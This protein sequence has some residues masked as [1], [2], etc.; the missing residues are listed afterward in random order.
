VSQAATAHRNWQTDCWREHRPFHCVAAHNPSLMAAAAPDDVAASTESLQA[1]SL[2]STHTA[3]PKHAPF[4]QPLAP[5][6]NPKPLAAAPSAVGAAASAATAAPKPPS[7]SSST[8]PATPSPSL[9]TALVDLTESST[10]TE[11]KDDPRPVLPF[12]S[13]YISED[14][15]VLDTVRILPLRPPHARCIHSARMLHGSYGV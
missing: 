4:V 14:Y 5:L 8:R 6:M 7:L 3:A 1:P 11:H 12:G 13:Y 2:S 9:E 10:E 15:N